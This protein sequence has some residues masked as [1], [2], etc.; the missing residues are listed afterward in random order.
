MVDDNI[1]R[2]KITK[3]KKL[4][5]LIRKKSGKRKSVEE[6]FEEGKVEDKETQTD[7]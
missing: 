3:Q 6:N 5:R 2:M 7:N 4:L 1:M